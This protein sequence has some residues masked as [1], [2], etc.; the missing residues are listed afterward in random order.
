M[1]RKKPDTN[2]ENLQKLIDKLIE[3]ISEVDPDDRD[4]RKPMVEQLNILYK[5]KETDAIVAS[6]KNENVA[7]FATIGAHVLGIVII[8]AYEQK[9]VI[10]SKAL[11]LLPKF[12]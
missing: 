5:L 12:R 11:A 10:T 6:K 2:S 3:D 4:N 9:S 1:P 7:A 8:V